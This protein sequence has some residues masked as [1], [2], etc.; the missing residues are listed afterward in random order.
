VHDLRVQDATLALPLTNLHF[1]R[2]FEVRTQATPCAVF[3]ATKA[4]KR[5]H[6]H[7]ADTRWGGRH[8]INNLSMNEVEHITTQLFGTTAVQTCRA[9]KHLQR[10]SDNGAGRNIVAAVTTHRSSASS[11]EHHLSP[12]QPATAPSQTP[13]LKRISFSRVA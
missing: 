9:C 5:V 10:S 13:I 8:L 11:D 7:S 3:C 4:C 1:F 6:R 2:R 12:S